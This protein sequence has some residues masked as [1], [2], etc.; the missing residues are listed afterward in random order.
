LRLAGFHLSSSF[1]FSNPTASEEVIPT[2]FPAEPIGNKYSYNPSDTEVLK[3]RTIE[4]TRTRTNKVKKPTPPIKAKNEEEFLNDL[5]LS[6]NLFIP[7][8]KA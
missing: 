3:I 8:P 1:P 5:P 2:V 7:L 4:G 6:N